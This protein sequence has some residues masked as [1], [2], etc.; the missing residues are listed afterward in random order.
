MAQREIAFAA[1]RAEHAEAKARRPRFVGDLL[2]GAM[3]NDPGMS[4][5]LF[6]FFR[7]RR[8]QSSFDHFYHPRRFQ[9]GDEDSDD[10]LE[11]DDRINEEHDNQ[12]HD[13]LERE[14]LNPYRAAYEHGYNEAIAREAEEG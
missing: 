14:E 11:L 13:D 6:V 5:F 10:D 8:C 2:K 12:Q 3:K 1:A 4:D 7:V 9:S